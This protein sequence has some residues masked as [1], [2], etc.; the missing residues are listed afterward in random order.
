MTK[1]PR[2][3]RNR[4]SKKG[5]CVASRKK[6]QKN[7]TDERAFKRKTQ[8]RATLFVKCFTWIFAA[9]SMYIKYFLFFVYFSVFFLVY[10]TFP[11]FCSIVARLS[12]VSGVHMFALFC[13][14]QFKCK[15]PDPRGF[16]FSFL[17]RITLMYVRARQKN[18]T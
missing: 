11:R 15:W 13:F 14:G 17:F 12:K 5:S 7:T 6:F 3:A 10:F 4:P 8:K 1:N 2:I 16:C 9:P 18:I